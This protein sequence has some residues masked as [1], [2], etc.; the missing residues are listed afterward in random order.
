MPKEPK[1]HYIPCFYLQQWTDPRG[2][3]IEYSR[4]GPINS[5]KTRPTSPKG[6]GFVRGLYRMD[7]IDPNVVNAVEEMFLKPSDG[8]AT[9]AL[10]AL[11]QGISFPK[12]TLRTSWSRFVLSLMIRYPE[13]IALMKAQ[14]RANVEKVYLQTRK[15]EEPP[16]F[17]EYEAQLGTRELARLHGKLL[18]DLMQRFED[19]AAYSSGCIGE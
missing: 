14:L 8:L 2:R 1:H 4:Q 5:V 10:E 16:T 6:T 18:M 9:D 15:P 3:L 11:L 12:P 13:A 19:G 17:A 7:D